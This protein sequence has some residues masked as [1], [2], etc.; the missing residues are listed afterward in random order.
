MIQVRQSTVYD[1]PRH[2]PLI[3]LGTRTMSQSGTCTVPHLHCSCP[4]I[5]TV[6]DAVSGRHKIVLK[7]SRLGVRHI[8]SGCVRV[9]DHQCKHKFS[10][11]PTSREAQLIYPSLYGKFLVSMRGKPADVDNDTGSFVMLC[12]CVTC[13]KVCICMHKYA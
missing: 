13:I 4:G 11:A 7:D 1:S 3:A 9:T 2:D 6:F 8:P 12:I 10:A 5:S